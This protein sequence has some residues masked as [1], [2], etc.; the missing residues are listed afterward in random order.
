[1][2]IFLEEQRKGRDEWLNIEQEQVKEIGL[3]QNNVENN[4][5]V[6]FLLY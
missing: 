3:K 6:T 4:A 1:M 2:K 5:L